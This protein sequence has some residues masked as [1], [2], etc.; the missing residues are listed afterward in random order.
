MNKWFIYTEKIKATFVSKIPDTLKRNEA[1]TVSLVKEMIPESLKENVV[2]SLVGEVRGE[3]NEIMRVDL[4]NKCLTFIPFQSLEIIKQGDVEK[5]TSG[6][7]WEGEALKGMI[8]VLKSN[9][10]MVESQMFYP[11]FE[12]WY[13]LD[14]NENVV[15]CFPMKDTNQQTKFEIT[16]SGSLVDVEGK[17]HEVSNETCFLTNIDESIGEKIPTVNMV[18]EKIKS[19]SLIR[20]ER[21][22]VGYVLLCKAEEGN[23][24]LGSFGCLPSYGG[25]FVDLNLTVVHSQD[26]HAEWIGSIIKSRQTGIEGGIS[27]IELVYGKVNEQNYIAL[28]ISSIY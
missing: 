27:N 17:S 5:T 9:G 6:F 14:S 12:I 18:E 3:G 8:E 20:I 11:S 4:E 23:H 28:K 21:S 2:K 25:Y 16:L 7:Q 15:M 19:I 26:D 24:Y 1:P 10:K 13:T 22:S